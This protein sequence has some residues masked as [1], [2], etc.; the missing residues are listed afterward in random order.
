MINPGPPTP[1][2]TEM[3]IVV[4]SIQLPNGVTLEYA[5]QGDASG[6]PLI[7]VNSIADSRRMFEPL[8]AH[9][10]PTIRAIA[11]S[12]R[13]HGNSSKPSSGYRPEDF[14]SDLDAFMDELGL[15]AAVI[16]GGSSG[17]VIA[18]RFAID[19]PERT[20]GLVLIGAP[21]SIGAKPGVQEMWDT[22]FSK[23]ADPLDPTLVREFGEQTIGPNVPRDLF[24]MMIEENLKAPAHVWVETMRGLIEDRS[25][26]ELPKI[27]SP[28]LVLYGEKDSILARDDHEA[29]ASRI[30]GARLVGYPGGGHAFYV[31]DPG[32]VAADLAEFVAEL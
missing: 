13:G 28:T 3:T 31:E 2:S 18:R 1:T 11:P 21:F 6:I 15:D 12:Q 25:A 8:M 24:E 19:R 22:T 27:A 29:M 26:D 14:A 9:L 32:P 23:L 16:A 5:E 20:K 30:A 17:G 10:P 7:F 4:D